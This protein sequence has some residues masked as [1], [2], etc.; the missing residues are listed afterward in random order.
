MTDLAMIRM[1]AV[2]HLAGCCF[3][4]RFSARSSMVS[5]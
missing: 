5:D 2:Y 3:G 1:H 4:L